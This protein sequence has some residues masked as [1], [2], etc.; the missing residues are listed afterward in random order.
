MGALII[1]ILIDILVVIAL[2]W[3]GT[4]PNHPASSHQA[5]T[6]QQGEEQK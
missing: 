6:P 3:Y 4:K 2:F 5:H 1:I